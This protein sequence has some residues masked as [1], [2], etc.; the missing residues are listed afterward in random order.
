MHHDPSQAWID[1]DPLLAARLKQHP[2]S[3]SIDLVNDLVAERLRSSWA[4]LRPLFATTHAYGH[5]DGRLCRGSRNAPR[6]TRSEVA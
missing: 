5:S 2:G 6:R 1:H 3:S 4:I